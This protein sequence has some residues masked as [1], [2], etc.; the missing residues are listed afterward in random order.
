M[1][2]TIFEMSQR[3]G[4]VWGPDNDYSQC[5]AWPGMRVNIS[6]H[7]GAFSDFPWPQNAD[8][9]PTTEEV[10]DYLS[11]YATHHKLKSH[12]RL[13]SKIIQIVPQEKK[14]LIR[15]NEHEEIKEEIFDSV[16]IA[17]SRFSNPHVPDFDG[18]DALKEK[19]LHSSQYKGA[20]RFKG[21]K[22]LVVGGSLS[23]TSIAEE[24]AK[25][26]HVTHLIRKSR[27][28]IKR[29]LSVDPL[30]TGP[31]LPRDLLKTY[32]NSATNKSP[33]EYYESMLQHCATQNQIPEWRMLP[34]SPRGFVVIEDYIDLVRS[35]RLTPVKGDVNHFTASYL[36]LENSQRL[37][38]DFVI[39]CTGYERH[40]DF[41]PEDLKLPPQ[42][43][44][45][46][47][48]PPHHENI[49]FIGMYP[50]GRGAVFPLVELQAKFACAVFSGSYKLPPEEIR[51]KEIETTSSTRDE[52]KFS[53]SLASK[54]NILPDLYS[55]SPA[56]KHVLINGAFTFARFFLKAPKNDAEKAM[57]WV[58]TTEHYRRKL[59]HSQDRVPS[60]ASQCF[61]TLE[62]LKDEAGQN[63]AKWNFTSSTS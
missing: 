44:Y 48:F 54:L 12:L 31:L 38:F 52:I 37:D 19:M 58:E 17:A 35:G 4:G 18:L 29:Y 41:I 43:L 13:K 30:N 47:T 22:V 42:E 25:V 5:G 3:I 53:M 15:W 9:F 46:D 60:L 14:W 24:V 62:R 33:Q 57:R 26:A 21:K 7:T 28:M 1:E 36:I 20:H 49:A 2:P 32:A 39:F 34:D 63:D 27:W 23:G 8:D 10:Y 6:R 40:L 16:I 45:E 50:T 55:C 11:A 51:L 61:F 59:L 56:L